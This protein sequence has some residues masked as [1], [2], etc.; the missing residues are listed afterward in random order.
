MTVTT[1]SLEQQTYHPEP[2]DEVAPL[3]SF[4]KA[5]QDRHGT[6]PALGYFLVGAEEHEQVE[7]PAAVYRVLVQV[8][9]AMMAGKSVTVVPQGELLT[10]QQAADLLGVSRPTVVTLIKDGH[11]FAQTPG[12]RRRLL[13]LDDVLAYRAKRRD[14]QYRALLETSTDDDD[15]ES[16][17]VIEDRMRRVRAEIAAERRSHGQSGQRG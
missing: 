7:I 1:Q 11:L 14:Q 13:K 6:T 2:I 5:H 10:T 9:E 15:L 17:E 12:R 16:V 8:L 3:L 4:I